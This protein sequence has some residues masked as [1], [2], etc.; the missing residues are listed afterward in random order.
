AAAIVQTSDQYGGFLHQADF[1]NHHSTWD[2]PISTEYRGHTIYECPPNGQGL[3][4]LLALNILSGFDLSALTPGSADALH[5]EIEA[6][7]LAFSDAATY[8]A[9]PAHAD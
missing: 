9:D 6:L 2:T 7:R 5:L 3:T 8:I 1:T 4:A